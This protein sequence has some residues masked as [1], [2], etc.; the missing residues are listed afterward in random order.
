NPLYEVLFALQN[1]PQDELKLP[2]LRVRRIPLDTGTAKFDLY[3]SMEEQEGTF[4]GAFEYRTDL[5]TAETIRRMAE[6]YQRI[7]K[8]AVAEPR[9]R[10]GDLPLLSADEERRVAVEYNANATAYPR[11]TIHHL[12]EA[13]VR[14]QPE[15]IAIACGGRSLSYGELNARANRLARQM[16]KLSPA[17]RV[18]GARVGIC[19]ERSSEMIVAMLAV[20]KTGGAYVPLDPAYPAR[21]I[22][23]ILADV[24]AALVITRDEHCRAL[25]EV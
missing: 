21:R 2:D 8:S 5:F 22:E 14:E 19:L 15:T 24:D 23:A 7:L 9:Q 13:I 4:R 18:S 3:L 25:A 11:E 6:Q 10:V 17:L 20:L 16:Q 1:A 12:F